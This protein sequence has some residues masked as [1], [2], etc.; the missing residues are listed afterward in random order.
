MGTSVDLIAR[1][2][3]DAQTGSA[4]IKYATGT[5]A[6]DITTS[7]GSL[8]TAAD[9]R[10]AR[11][12]LARNNVP[13]PDGRFYV[14]IVHPDTVHEIYNG[15]IGEF[16]G[17]RFVET[18]NAALTSDGASGTVD[19]YTSYFLGFQCIAYAE[20]QAPMMGM[21]GPF[22]ALQR[23]MNVYWYGLFGFGELRPE[24]LFKVYSASSVGANT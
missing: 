12:R 11:N 9:V 2:A 21:S 7:P 14:A 6:T 3:Y 4:Y 15:E 16:E 20:G 8:L 22:D 19:L 23:L 1:A 24:A 10:F 13:K 17:F 5:S 18:S